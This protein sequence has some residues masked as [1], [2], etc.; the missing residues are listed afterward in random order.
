MRFTGVNA[1]NFF[2]AG[3][4]L[5]MAVASDAAGKSPWLVLLNAALCALNLAV[6]LLIASSNNRGR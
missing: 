2:V 6:P 4:C 3:W 5:A 1:F